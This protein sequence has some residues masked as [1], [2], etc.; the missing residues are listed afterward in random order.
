MGGMVLRRL[1]AAAQ[2]KVKG[3][4]TSRAGSV[5]T[6]HSHTYPAGSENGDL[7]LLFVLSSRSTAGTF[8]HT[9]PANWTLV[10]TFDAGPSAAQRISVFRK[11]RVAETT[12]LLNASV[13]CNWHVTSVALT[14][15]YAD[16]PIEN[17]GSIIHEVRSGFTVETSPVPVGSAAGIVYWGGGGTGGTTTPTQTW[18]RGTELTDDKVSPSSPSSTLNL[19]TAFENVAG[20]GVVP[21]NTLTHSIDMAQHYTAVVAVR[22]S[23]WVEPPPT[24]GD[25]T[26]GVVATRGGTVVSLTGT[27]FRGTGATTETVV[28]VGGVAV[29]ASSIDVSSPT[30]MS[31][32]MPAGTEGISNITVTTSKGTSNSLSFNYVVIN[33]T[34]RKMNKSGTQS[35]GS[36]TGNIK[37]TG[38]AR[39]TSNPVTPTEAIVNNELVVDG[40]GNITITASGFSFSSTS[41][42]SG[43]RLYRNGVQIETTTSLSTISWTGDVQAGDSFALYVAK[44]TTLSRTVNANGSLGYTVNPPPVLVASYDFTGTG[45]LDTTYWLPSGPGTLKVVN[46]ELDG[47]DTPSVPLSFAWWKVPVPGTGDFKVTARIRWNGRSPE[48]SSTGIAVRGDPGNDV[49]GIPG[50]GNGIQFAFTANI[51]SLY[52]EKT[53]QSPAFVSLTGVSYNNTSKYPENALLEV[54]VRGTSYIAK[55]NGVIKQQGTTTAIPTSRRMVGLLIQND[56]LEPGGGG[57]PGRLAEFR[58]YQI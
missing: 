31:V 45:P 23:S 48:H 4:N 9:T 35:L 27:G 2:V 43:L 29:P 7:I 19:S 42:M 53:N 5:S 6:S 1:K 16:D 21:S 39:E 37:I 3:T 22:P 49:S 44:T 26:P 28:K 52:Y 36:S 12:V 40:D 10:A 46:G 18:A 14:D 30:S 55:V 20:A 54:E 47:D 50:S 56:E 8:T 13:S 51:E 57:P 38:W 32:V 11:V 25:I 41:S 17:I 58:V 34:P 15:F 24:L 33:I